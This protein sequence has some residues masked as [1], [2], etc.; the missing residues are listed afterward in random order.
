MGERSSTV[1]AGASSAEDLTQWPGHPT[2]IPAAAGESPGY[3]QA[4][5]HQVSDSCVEDNDGEN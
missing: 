3:T 2:L 4:S 5:S 1:P